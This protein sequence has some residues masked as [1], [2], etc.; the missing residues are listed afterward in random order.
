MIIAPASLAHDG[1][2]PARAV[3]RL[4]PLDSLSLDPGST[5]PLQRQLYGQLR[6]MLEERLLPPG[7]RLQSSR[8]L[9]ADLGISRTTV[10]SVYDQLATEGYV[11]CRPGARAVVI[12]LPSPSP[13]AEFE[14]P[15]GRRLLSSRGAIMQEQP[16]HHGKPGHLAFH[17]GMP[18]SDYF[19]F[20]TWSR[21]LARRATAAKKD[22]F[23]SH[24]TA[25]YRPLREAI[26]SYV[27]VARGVRC[28]V[29]QIVITAG[30]QP[31]LDLMARVLLD[32]G[33]TAWVEEPGYYGA[34]AAFVA[35]GATLHPLHVGN[36]GW[37]IDLDQTVV[38]R[39]IYVTPASQQ[40]LGLTM[41][42]E[43]RLQLIDMADRADAFI[44]ED[45]FDG[46]YR[47]HGSPI[48]AMQG[49][50]QADRVIYLGTFSKL[51]FPALRVGFMV[52]PKSLVGRF[53]N[54]LRITGQYA[55]PLIQAALADF[56]DG[57]YMT[58]HLRR[59]R[60]IYA[61]RREAFR[62]ISDARLGRW[63]SLL[64]GDA[65]ISLV[66]EF[67]DGGDDVALAAAARK[68]LLNVTPLSMH[69]RHGLPREGIV[70]G[71]AA[72]PESAMPTAFARLEDAFRETLGDRP[73]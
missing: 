71:Y 28:T 50:D 34:Q 9:A 23:G 31:A 54:P 20:G 40:P 7:S 57:G 1:V 2:Q 8:S 41:R 17:P 21:L 43:Q 72:L 63:M 69:Y 6:R 44:I 55:S 16:H 32:P 62:Q 18:D 24:D 70:M 11:D 27:K 61:A 19:P 42:M 4:L 53:D 47:F 67:N 64:P 66:G 52:L 35:A 10:V 15:Q 73:A 49:A 46:E 3:R 25:G 12:D 5:T 58:T 14:A 37:N 36:A 48:P 29:E 30:A 33:D 39:L 13:A 68:R 60:R 59:M 26:A 45:D 38:P 65:G 51:L 56:I 22:L